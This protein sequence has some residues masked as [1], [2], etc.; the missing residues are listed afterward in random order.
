MEKIKGVRRLEVAKEQQK[1]QSRRKQSDLDTSER[2]QLKVTPDAKEELISCGKTNESYTTIIL[3][4]ARFY[5][6]YYQQHKEEEEL[7]G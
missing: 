5:K 4:L 3:K 1:R 2:T 7:E 6:K